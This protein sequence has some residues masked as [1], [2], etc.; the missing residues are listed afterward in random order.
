MIELIDLVLIIC[1]VVFLILKMGNVVNWS[2]WFILSPGILTAVV[3]VSIFL[4]DEVKKEL[5]DR[6]AFREAMRD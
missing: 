5:R 4:Y 3:I 2:W 6:K 1:Q